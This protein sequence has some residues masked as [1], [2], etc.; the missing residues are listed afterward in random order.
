MERGL[1]TLQLCGRSHTPSTSK[2]SENMLSMELL[3]QQGL[4]QIS[5]LGLGPRD[6]GFTGVAHISF[7]APLFRFGEWPA[8]PAEKIAH[9]RHVS[10]W[11]LCLFVVSVWG[12]NSA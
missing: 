5:G 4:L 6:F 2:A 8:R 7:C 1:L 11:S 12:L 9:R 3:P 10:F